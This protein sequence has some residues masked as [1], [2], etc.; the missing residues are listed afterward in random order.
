MNDK[1]LK[2]VDL[3]CFALLAVIRIHTEIWQI[4]LYDDLPSNFSKG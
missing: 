4:C 3:A 1:Y 2:S